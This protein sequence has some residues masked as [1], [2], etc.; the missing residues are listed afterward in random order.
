M[1]PAPTTAASPAEPFRA[2]L[3]EAV[4]RLLVI[5]DTLDGDPDFED[6]ADAE[7]SLGA[8]EGHVSQLVWLRGT[9]SDRE[10]ES[11]APATAADIFA[12]MAATL[13]EPARW[14]KG[15]EARNAAG[16]RVPATDPRAVCWCL[17]GARRIEL[18]KVKSAAL[19]R[20]LDDETDEAL[21]EAAGWAAPSAINDGPTT[22]HSEVLNL[23]LQA[24]SRDHATA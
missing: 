23:I 15:A 1:S 22:S 18:A 19:R 17:Y 12:G 16:E 11:R 10:I 5:L 2:R 13:A 6:G 4:E 20:R 24:T 3:E 8:P 21:H 14:T 9:D 7:P